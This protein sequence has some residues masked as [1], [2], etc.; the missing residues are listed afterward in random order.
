MKTF[1]YSILLFIALTLLLTGNVSA[2]APA[3]EL[4]GHTERMTIATP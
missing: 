3:V 1:H 2:D 4:K